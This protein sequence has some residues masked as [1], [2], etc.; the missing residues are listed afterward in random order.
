M[1]VC[2]LA[3]GLD[4]VFKAVELPAGVADLDACLADMNRND[5]AH[6]V[7]FELASTTVHLSG[8][9]SSIREGQTQQTQNDN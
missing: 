8:K 6:G 4:A 2:Y 5:F 3:V 7:F 1:S 9:D